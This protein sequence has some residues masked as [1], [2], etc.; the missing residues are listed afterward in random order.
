MTIEG[1]SS[2]H[3]QAVHLGPT[4]THVDR[5]TSENNDC[6]TVT[7]VSERLAPRCVVP[8]QPRNMIMF[9]GRIS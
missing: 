8:Q 9:I 4:A 5:M 2:L 6:A 3:P 1:E 7:A